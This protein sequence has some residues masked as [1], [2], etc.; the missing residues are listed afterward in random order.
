MTHPKIVILEWKN[1]PD[2]K[3]LHQ[4]IEFQKTI[5]KEFE[6]VIQITQGYCSLMLFHKKKCSKY[7]RLQ[8]KTSSSL[9]ITI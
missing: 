2:D 3:T 5:L 6:E 9:Y 7:R 4:L 1:E 8:N